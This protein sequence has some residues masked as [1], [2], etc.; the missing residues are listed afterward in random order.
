M[1]FVLPAPSTR[2]GD[3]PTTTQNSAQKLIRLFSLA[4]LFGLITSECV[5]QASP[6]SPS[7]PPF[8][9]PPTKVTLELATVPEGLPAGAQEENVNFDLVSWETFVA[10]NWP[11]DSKTCSADLTKTIL[12]GTGPVVWETY[13][14]DTDVFVSN[15]KTSKPAAWCGVPPG[16]TGLTANAL[17]SGKDTGATRFLGMLSKFG[18]K[19]TAGIHGIQEVGGALTDRNGRF[20][21]YE[22]RMNQDEYNYIVQNNLW[23]KAGQAG[24][25]INF[26]EGKTSWGPVGAME[27]KAAWKILGA[28]DDPTKFYKIQ[29]IVFN[30]VKGTKSPGKNP[31]TLGLVGLHILHKAKGQTNWLWS[32][33]EQNDNVSSFSYPDGKPNVQTAKAPYIEL[34]PKGKPIN[35]PVNVVRVNTPPQD[36]AT[37]MNAGFQK[38]LAGSVWANYSLVAS[39][40]A[41]NLGPLPKPPF[42]ANTVIETYTQG[43]KPPSD[44]PIPWPSPGYQPFS[45]TASSSCMKC[46]SVA[47]TSQN[48]KADFSFL[49]GNAQ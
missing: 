20:V 13:L 3:L 4:I 25:T 36:Q 6:T 19:M 22:I 16:T 24:K 35:L 9:T 37:V 43:P 2:L 7:G 39:Q 38:L 29:A 49:L 17:K 23:N 30:D 21:R 15:P 26:P 18:A 14:A 32:T 41:G 48:T 45:P 47:T 31:V 12:S 10:L 44:G 42:M 5:A 46:H 34:D 27:V 33:F 11:A 28:G 40:W 8:P 1:K